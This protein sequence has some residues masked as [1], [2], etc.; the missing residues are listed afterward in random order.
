MKT[1]RR[2]EPLEYL[3]VGS[4][5]NPVGYRPP[6]AVSGPRSLVLERGHLAS[7]QGEGPSAALTR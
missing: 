4:E 5:E 3:A 2:C 6:C 1:A 7:T